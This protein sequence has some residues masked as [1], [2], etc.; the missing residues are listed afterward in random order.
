MSQNNRV[1]LFK[2]IKKSKVQRFKVLR[3]E[4]ADRNLSVAW[5]QKERPDACD[6]NILSLKL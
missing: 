1:K 4:D 6:P 2:R 5:L 3:K